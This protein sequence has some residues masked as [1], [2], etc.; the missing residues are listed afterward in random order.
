MTENQN[1]S[2]PATQPE[3]P[4]R[5]R[6]PFREFRKPPKDCS[7]ELHK[8]L[9]ETE[10]AQLNDLFNKEDGR[11]MNKTQLK[12]VLA[13]VAR[14]DFPPERFEVEFLKMNASCNGMVTWDEFI[15]YLILGFELQEVSTE[16]KTLAAP[17]PLGPS[18]VK[19]NHRHTI[20][21]IT[22]YPT[23]KPD[24]T[25]SWHDGSIMTCSHD[26][27][28]NYWTLDMTPERQVQST[29]P[30]LKIQSTWVTD[31]AVLPDVSVICTSSSERDI[32]FYDTSAR[33]FE[34]RVMITTLEYAVYTM[35]YK[36]YEDPN[37]ESKLILGDMGGGV[38]VLYINTFARGPFRS[39]PGIP[40][41]HVR[42][43]AIVKGLVPHFRAASYPNLHT[44]YV[45]QVSFCSILHSAVSCSQCPQAGLLMTDVT[46][47]KNV[48]T[49]KVTAGVWCFALEETTHIVATGS[50][51]CLIR[52]WN[53]FVPHRPT[54]LFYG[55]HTGIVQLVFQDNG[56]MLYSLSKDKSIKVWDIAVQTCLQTY[57]ELPQELGER[58]ELTALYNPESRQWIIASGM[59]AVIPLSP[60][61]SSEHTDGNTHS[62]A[63]SVVLY[64][65]LFKVI[66]TC[67]LDSYII[68]W[69]PWDGRR[70]LVIKEGHTRML[71][72]EIMSVEITAATFDPGYQRLLTGA[73][74]GTLKI[75]NFNTGTCLRNMNIETWCEVQSVIW[76]NNRILAMGWNKRVTEFA[77]TGEAVGPEGAFSKNWD[78]RHS[79]D[80]SAAAVRVPESLA[81]TSYVGELLLWRLETGQ[82]YKKFIVSNPT[83]RIKIHFTVE[84]NKDKHSDS[85]SFGKYA[86]RLSMV[87]K[88]SIASQSSKRVTLLPP[89]EKTLS[90]PK[91]MGRKGRMSMIQMP[92]E[93]FNLRR[94]AVHCMLFLSARKTEPEVGTLLVSLENGVI[95]VWNHH[96]SGG[97]IT[98]FNA[99]HKAGD[100]VIAMT[101]D[102]NNEFLFTGTTAG[103]IKTWLMKNY[104]MLPENQEHICLP[105]Y[106]L[107]F[108]F[109][110][111]DRFIGR[112]SR[113]V[114]NQPFPI[115]L[116]SYKG[117]FMPVSGLTYLEDSRILISCSADFSTRMWTL[118]GR[119]LQTIGTFK[120]W[121]PIP[122]DGNL[123][124][125]F[126][127]T[128]PP[129][130]KR[131]GSSTTL[132]VLSGGSFPKRLTFK[133][134]QKQAEKDLVHV[135]HSKIY[136]ARLSDPILGHNYNVFERLSTPKEVKFDTSFPYIP[137][138]QHLI[139]PQPK[140]IQ[141]PDVPIDVP[142]NIRVDDETI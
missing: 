75:W 111:G 23:V 69:N 73:H 2:K 109:M 129:D 117:H 10:L 81:T 34:L 121:K 142:N 35:H 108:P 52:L 53:P 71:H 22:F 87:C 123:P 101:T 137:V 92:E 45:R 51:D 19:S 20:N 100:Y 68:V 107:M 63:V 25:W 44:D 11:R 114:A 32:R 6:L 65:K 74:D 36:F 50:P 8:L 15:S 61:Q 60:K 28:I 103:Y 83:E 33:K 93:C 70:L 78:L 85:F 14:I 72:G 140:P 17:I 13:K 67:G 90:G 39:Q 138:Y 98:S 105:K 4:K 66:V 5:Y 122:Q 134:L 136:G 104:C 127:Y 132:R 126:E 124:D 26:G 96:V 59:I 135:D 76:V 9:D 120:P 91:V 41:L 42:W 54:C 64:N 49:Y 99:V 86:N 37:T 106:R 56:K 128:I 47:S 7:K 88:Q 80:I 58:S 57:L 24:R 95:Q 112:A 16:Y 79:E 113:M 1:I 30:E 77:D 102:V 46:D 119:Y 3:K 18:L 21:R 89:Q 27:V 118:A 139:M 40:L 133:Q 29:C 115:L 43:S 110:W 94:L 84:K 55:H 62:S 130:I 82:P 131:V 12:E 38:T 125:D 48:Y 116:N 141:V 31:F 97:F